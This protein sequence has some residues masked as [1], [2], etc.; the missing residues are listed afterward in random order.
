[1]KKQLLKAA[2]YLLRPLGAVIAGKAALDKAE[3]LRMDSMVQRL[4]QRNVEVATIIDIGA[5][6]GS[7]SL[8]CRKHFPDA[9]YLAIEPLAEQQVAL[10]AAKQ[11]F[12]NFDYALCVAGET[13]GE[14]V[15]LAVTADLDGS[16]VGGRSAGSMRTCPVRTL[17]SLVAEKKL[18]GPYL[19]KF[20]THGYEMPILAGSERVLAEATAIIMEVYNFQLTPT[21]LRF[22]E[23]CAHLEGLGFRPA[24]IAEPMLRQY[25]GAFWQVDFLF[26]RS[27]FTGFKHQTYQ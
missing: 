24:D 8:A 14:E 12:S 9:S 16:T 20:D 26:L 5:S 15:E 10:E 13:D 22:H 3:K 25:D 17:D 1:M 2:N 23:M 6:N 27:D 18:T 19:L 7:W 4:A 21:T 11:Q